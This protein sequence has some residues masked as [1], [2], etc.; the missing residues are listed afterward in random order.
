MTPAAVAEQRRYAVP[1][2]TCIDLDEQTPLVTGDRIAG[3]LRFD[4]Q[5][6]S[7]SGIA[8]EAGKS[9]ETGWR[10]IASGGP[11]TTMLPTSPAARAAP[12]ANVLSVLATGETPLVLSADPALTW[13]RTISEFL[14]EALV[15]QWR[16]LAVGPSAPRTETASRE[17]DGESE[18]EAWDAFQDL[19]RWLN[20]TD[21]ETADLLG[22]GKKTAYG[23]RRTGHPP[24][25]RL[26]RRVYEAHA[27]VRQ[28]VSIFGEVEAA[29]LIH[30]G[31]ANSA[32]ALIAA[33]RVA[34]AEARFASV[35]YERPRRA[36]VPLE[37]S[38]SGDEDAPGNDEP[39]VAPRA[40][41]R[42]RVQVRRRG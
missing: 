12:W 32:A 30:Q 25:P 15:G 41:G 31:G 23:W 19:R 28:M 18:S 38:Q 13:Q 11:S 4:S 40:G 1:N 39:A 29:R 34:E 20:L 17:P 21:E 7:W 16:A 24:Q 6:E 10:L 37:A 9:D 26:A 8:F 3:I 2:T 5:T 42:R 22:L 33:N 36:E 35:M 14:S 27:F